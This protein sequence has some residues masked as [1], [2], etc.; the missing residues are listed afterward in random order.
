[1][2]RTT[3]QQLDAVDAAIAAIEGGAQSISVLGRLYQRGSL[4]AL[5][6]ERHRLEQKLVQ[7]SRGG[8]RI[9]LARPTAL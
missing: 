7:E 2:A 1:M 8:S 9:R 6:D 4:Q 3:Q 5:Y